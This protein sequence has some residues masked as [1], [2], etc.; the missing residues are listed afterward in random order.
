MVRRRVLVLTEMHPGAR[1]VSRATRRGERTLIPGETSARATDGVL[2]LPESGGLLRWPW[3]TPEMHPGARPV[4]RAPLRFLKPARARQG[5]GR[6][7]RTSASQA[8]EPPRCAVAH[9]SVTTHA[10]R[11]TIRGVLE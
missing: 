1:P 8:R 4:S 6:G 2:E 11:E 5:R 10:R 9:T 3:C 7:N